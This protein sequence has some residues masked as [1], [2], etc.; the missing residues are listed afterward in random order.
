MRQHARRPGDSCPNRHPPQHPGR[1]RAPGA[2]TDQATAHPPDPIRSSLSASRHHR[3][4]HFGLTTGLQE[5]GL[6]LVGTQF[7]AGPASSP[8]VSFGPCSSVP[9]S[10]CHHR[11]VPGC[12][13]S[14]AAA[15]GHGKLGRNSLCT[16]SGRSADNLEP[17][18]IARPSPMPINLPATQRLVN[19]QPPT[20]HQPAPPARQPLALPAY[21]PRTG[22]QQA[23]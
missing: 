19:R 5:H 6:T 4:N 18:R 12:R 23:R 3:G 21:R 1:G 15:P 17:N 11:P 8:Y 20:D 13:P 7:S 9:A 16:L 14:K 10:G 22:Q 2:K